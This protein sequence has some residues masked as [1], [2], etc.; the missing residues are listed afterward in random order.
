MPYIHLSSGISHFG[1]VEFSL[2]FEKTV[3]GNKRPTPEL[4][5][6]TQKAKCCTGNSMLGIMTGLRGW[7]GP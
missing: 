6:L 1:A 3:V 2:T 7:L 5:G 4:S